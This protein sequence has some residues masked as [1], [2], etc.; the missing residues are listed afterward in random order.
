MDD[1]FNSPLPVNVT[2]GRAWITSTS[3]GSVTVT[4]TKWLGG[5]QPTLKSPKLQAAGLREGAET[6]T[7][8]RTTEVRRFS[9]DIAGNVEN[10]Y[11]PDGKDTRY[12]HQVVRVSGP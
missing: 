7:V 4:V 3:G 1:Q 12:R 6:L 5:P 8:S 10:H 2:P 9:V 11:R